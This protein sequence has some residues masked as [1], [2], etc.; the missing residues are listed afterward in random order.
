MRLKRIY[1]LCDF[2]QLA[3]NQFPRNYAALSELDNYDFDTKTVFTEDGIKNVEMLR[4]ATWNGHESPLYALLDHCGVSYFQGQGYNL[5]SVEHLREKNW[6]S[7]ACCL[8]DPFCFTNGLFE[9]LRSVPTDE[10]LPT[11]YLWTG[12]YNDIGLLI[13]LVHFLTGRVKHLP[14]AVVLSLLPLFK[15][16]VS[17]ADISEAREQGDAD[18]DAFTSTSI[19]VHNG[20]HGRLIFRM[21]NLELAACSTGD[22]GAEL[23]Q[24]G[25]HKLIHLC[26]G[27]LTSPGPDVQLKVFNHHTLQAVDIQTNFD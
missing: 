12:I 3:S 26:A 15:D 2:E 17:E 24:L 5:D 9:R 27:H 21:V 16:E 8:F 18:A 10:Q 19:Y 11:G 6:K 7:S 1:N 25:M 22:D 20:G 23:E 4:V 13:V 14:R